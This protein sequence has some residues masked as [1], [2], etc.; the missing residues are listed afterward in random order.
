MRTVNIVTFVAASILVLGCSE[1]SPPGG[2]PC[3]TFNTTLAIRDRMNQ[4]ATVFAPGEEIA[5][6][7]TVAN[8]TYTSATLTAGSTCTAVV[9]E[10]FDAGQNRLWGSADDI[11][12]I[13]MLQPRTYLP[14]ESVHYED[15]WRPAL[16]DNLPAPPSVLTVTANVGQ[17]MTDAQGRQHECRS[18]LSKSATF[19][20]Q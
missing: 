7:L 11:A 5:F 10:V 1:E 19:T 12:C 18:A 13:Q 8:V 17:F 2:D 14:F 15:T 16:Y 6:D 3:R 4:P 9:F 20:I